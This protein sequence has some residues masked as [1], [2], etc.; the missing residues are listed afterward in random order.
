M[1]SFQ[2]LWV[3]SLQ[4]YL[5]ALIVF[6]AAVATVTVGIMGHI[7]S[8]LVGLA[9]AYALMVR[10]YFPVRCQRPEGPPRL[11][12]TCLLGGCLGLRPLLPSF[13]REICGAAESRGRSGLQYRC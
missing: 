2:Y 5:G 13:L 12:P 7:S 9:I 10:T 11:R 3:C 1:C 6:A 4:D 8:G